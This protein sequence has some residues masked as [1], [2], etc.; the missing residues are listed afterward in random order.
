MDPSTTTASDGTNQDDQLRNLVCRVVSSAPSRPMSG[1]LASRRAISQATPRLHTTVDWSVDLRRHFDRQPRTVPERRHLHAPPRRA[2]GCGGTL[3]VNAG[4]NDQF[5]IDSNIDLDPPTQTVVISTITDDVAPTIGTV[6]D[7]G[8]T[9]D[10]APALAG[11]LSAILGV[12]EVLSIFR[13][14]VKI[15]DGRLSPAPTGPS[16]TPPAPLVDGHQLHLHRPG[17][18]R[19]QQSRA[20]QQC[21]RHHHR[22]QRPPDGGGG[23]ITDDMAP[24]TPA[25][26]PTTSPP[27]TPPRHWPA[28]CRPFWAPARCCRSSATASRSA[29]PMS[30]APARRCTIP[31]RW[32]TAPA[33]PTPPGSRTPPT[34]SG[35]PAMPTTSP[36]TPAPPPRRW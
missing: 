5:M 17:R 11:T 9:N 24:T 20:G 31:D 32:S 30:P 28:R 23:H 21:L 36:S 4:G 2:G 15:G 6:A 1:R 10:T 29:R 14:G 22:H 27:A 13:D 12:G 7:G 8:I 34:I 18:G 26:S 3:I 33:T 35:R 16:P 25:R 19:R